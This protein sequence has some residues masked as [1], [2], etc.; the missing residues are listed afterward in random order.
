MIRFFA[1]HPTA[2]NLLMVALVA[3]GLLSVGNLRR[4]T[5]PHFAARKVEV[6]VVYPGAAAEEVEDAICRR[7]EDALER[8]DDSEEMI[9]EAREGVGLV[10]VEMASTGDLQVFLDDIR[11]EIDAID[12][13]PA[14][15]EAP[16]IV[17]RG[18]TDR[19]I[20][21]GVTANATVPDLKALCENLEVR[22]RRETG[23]GLVEL[24][25]FSDH[26]LR[27]E[28]SMQALQQHGLSVADVAAVVQGQSVDLPA[29]TI[30]T[31]ENE[32]LVRFVDERRTP[33]D[34]AELVIVAVP[35]AGEIRLG[36]L[37]SVTDRFELDEAKILLDGRRAGVLEVHKSRSEDTLRVRDAVAAFVDRERQ[38]LPATV[39]LTLIEDMSSIVRDRLQMLTVNGIQGLVLVFITMAL[40]FSFRFSFWVAM[41]LPVSFLGGLWAMGVLDQSINMVSMV[42]LLLAL[43]LLMDDAIV[44]AENIAAQRQR[45]K[46]PLEAV[47]DGVAQVRNGVIS[48][49]LTTVCIFGPLL[50]VEGQMGRVL[51]VMPVVLI[52]VLAVSLI[53]AFL[54]LPNHLS[55]TLERMGPDAKRGRI[56][57]A[58]DGSIDWLRERVLGPAVDFCVSYRYL[59]VGLAL[60]ILV[61]SLAQVA[62][63]R[64]KRAAFPEIDGDVIEARLLLPQGTPLGRTDDVVARITD[65][66]GRV[67]ERFRPRQ[68]GGAALVQHVQVAFNVNRDA[69]ESGPHVATVTAD[70]L[71]A[72]TRDARID[73]IFAAWREEI[74]AVPG[75]IALQFKEPAIGPAGLAIE[76]RLLGD[77]LVLLKAASTDLMEWL[78]GFPGVLD[79]TDD[80]RPGKREVR[81]RLQ[82]GATGLGLSAGEIARQLRAAF[83]GIT[84]SEIQV[85]REA[86]EIDVRLAEQ[87]RSSLAD[88]ETF[89]VV[90]PGGERVPLVQVAR[91]DEGRGPARIAH[92]DGQRAVTIQGDIDRS[93]LNAEELTATLKAK[94]MPGFRERHPDV[95]LVLAGEAKESKTTGSSIT[96]ALMIGLLGVFFIL[97]FQFRSWI[98]PLMVMVAIPFSLVGVIWGH[99]ALGL[100]LTLPSI[101]GFVSLAG[102]VVN[103]SI[104]LVVFI[105]MRRAEGVDRL[106][107]ARQAGRDRFRA[108]LLTSLT[109]IAGLLPLLAERSLQAQILI[110]LAASIVFGLLASTVLVLLVLPAMYSILGDIRK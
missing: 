29:G 57:R 51:R 44:L 93:K 52:L 23:V 8:V 28:L 63:G 109:T 74:G 97:S 22:M 90:L 100:D 101:F 88:L 87:D 64:L 20:S 65:A 56:R 53:E 82:E 13:W 83:Q 4:E 92:V 14:L 41:G 62:S 18:R 17:E 76:I 3:I 5:F 24:R 67:D 68:P 36:D 60:G 70:L 91:F 37:G 21:V 32:I 10:V 26:Q 69:F 73:E 98:E 48:S 27:V 7:I 66:L 58:V 102:V 81:L 47:V 96:R 107:A 84:A 54:I 30:T 55:H 86:Y 9:S 95:E 34:L 16:V 35:G 33:A 6:R 80:L 46:A 103:D 110:P 78:N 104:L 1:S 75:V 40:F 61:F 72:E 106:D 39:E 77:D 11:S 15:A 25:G 71:A 19:V 45:G 94:F 85:G 2:A 38:R 99:L 108:V 42:G 59:T 12:D 89:R 105:K 49:F 31:R 43:G 50:F 79:L